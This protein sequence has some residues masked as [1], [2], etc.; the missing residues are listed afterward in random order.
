MDIPT[1]KDSHWLSFFDVLKCC[2][3]AVEFYSKIS[4]TEIEGS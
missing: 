4:Y 2:K 1:K 3:F